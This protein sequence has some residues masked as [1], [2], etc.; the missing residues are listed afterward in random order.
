MLAVHQPLHRFEKLVTP[1][2]ASRKKPQYVTITYTMK[3]QWRK[4]THTRFSHTA[5]MDGNVAILDLTF[6]L[7]LMS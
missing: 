5:S 1:Q 3:D 7:T 6:N 4:Q 2:F